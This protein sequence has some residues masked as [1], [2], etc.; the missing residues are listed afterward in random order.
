MCVLESS[1]TGW[2]DPVK[3]WHGILLND[4]GGDARRKA[5]HSP[6]TRKNKRDPRGRGIQL[7]MVALEDVLDAEIIQRKGGSGK[8]ERVQKLPEEPRGDGYSF[9]EKRPE[10]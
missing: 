9:I 1:S 5:I 8:R 3:L 10:G 7:G 4:A 2:F 6:R